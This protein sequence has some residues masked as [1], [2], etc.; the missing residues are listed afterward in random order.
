MTVEFGLALENF[1]PE[2]KVPDMD[3]ITAYSATAEELGFASVWA[4]DHLFLGARRP[5]PFLEAL[6][7]LSWVAARTS[8]IMLGTGV[9]VLPIREPAI[10][11]KTTATL[12]LAS[13]GRL[14]LGVASGW[15]E[16]E[17]DAT[18]VP[19][20]QRGQIFE[21][22]LDLML[23]LWADDDV[24]GEWDGRVLTHVRMLPLPR[25]RPQ[26]LIGG[27]VD[28]VLRRVATR[29]DGWVTYFY[30]AGSIARAWSAIRGYAEQAG[31]DPA[32][33]NV[34]AQVPLCIGSSYEEAT[35]RAGEYVSE[36][37]DVPAWSEATPDSAVRGTPQ[38]C[39]EQIAALIDAG[40]RHLVF[41]PYNY[42]AEQVHRLATEVLPLLSGIRAGARLMEQVTVLA[43]RAEREAAGRPVADKR[44][45]AE[46][47]AALIRDGDHV[48]IGGT[49]YS[50]TP[51]AL[52]FALLR[53]RR[54]HLTVSR[55][56]ACYEIELFLATG[57]LD[58]IV[59]SW[60]GIG[61]PWGLA[62]VF[63][64]YV[65]RGE[66]RYDEWS[67]LA[68]G[69]R[70][71]AG[72]MGVPFLPSLTML[73]S[74]LAGT[75][76]LQTVDCPYTGE[77]LAAVPALNPDVALIH[78]HRADMFGNVQVD[79][80][81]HM[82]ADMAKA[83]RT[84]IVSAER[85]VSPEEIAAS[86]AQTMLPHFA[87]DA[88]VAAPHGSYPHECYGLYGPDFEHFT[89]YAAATKEQGPAG[90]LRY[91]EENVDGHAGFAGFIA[92][93]GPERLAALAADAGELMGR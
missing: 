67:H 21:R 52:V 78:A 50:R 66:A 27:Y 40:V 47:A 43:A 11:A 51:M 61:L 45:T 89:A 68:M 82:D 83:A 56:L 23:R 24:T 8:R 3:A 59:T 81:R 75:L 10:V 44:M 7:T 74:D 26:L 37:F 73:G 4:W 15:Y 29:S 72:A 77:Q 17:F 6:T 58:R 76:G 87:V 20:R 16:R 41:C 33:L 28:R 34:V 38:Q 49:L 2:R 79:G 92:A 9:L 65:E 5:F 90:A 60:V 71:K 91:V 46:D 35:R 39:A 84:V 85:I 19:F 30:T 14:M 64:H 36:Y 88:V 62:P 13:G 54:R 93:A 70:Y 18:A 57:A 22:N 53:Q 32:Q 1:T 42:E 12:Q 63:R 86:P 69:L 31:R 48:A 80:Y 25:P 55:P